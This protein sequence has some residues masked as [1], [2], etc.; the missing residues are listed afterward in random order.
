MSKRRAGIVALFVVGS[1]WLAFVQAFIAFAGEFYARPEYVRSIL[2]LSR[3]VGYG[4]APW[5]FA[6]AGAGIKAGIQRARGRPSGFVS[7]LLLGT[8]FL[9]ALLCVGDVISGRLTLVIAL[10]LQ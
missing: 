6:A 10:L 7:S 4:L 5:L 1:V 9:I 2:S 8:G 3:G